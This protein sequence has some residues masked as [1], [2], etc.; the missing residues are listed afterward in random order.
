[1]DD[2][3][4]AG[5]SLA[6][7]LALWGW[8]THVAAD[9]PSGLARIEE[10]RPEVVIL[11]IGM[12]GMDGYQVAREL[13]RREQA[14]GPAPRLLIALTGFGQREDRERAQAAGFD[15]HLTK[16]ADPDRLRALLEVTA[17]SVP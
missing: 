16:P 8:E 7:L 6:E 17:A 4:D 13:R 10:L 2:N 1:V 9:G 11:D 15:H 14:G 5:E 12:P 3:R